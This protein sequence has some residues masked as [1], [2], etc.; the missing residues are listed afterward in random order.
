M[1]AIGLAVVV[2]VITIMLGKLIL[3]DLNK[4]FDTCLS[5]AKTEGWCSC[6][7]RV[8]DQIRKHYPD[9]EKEL[10]KKLLQKDDYERE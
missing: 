9:K 4:I 1:L 10:N 5:K 7:E 8:K 2:V 3:E 6:E